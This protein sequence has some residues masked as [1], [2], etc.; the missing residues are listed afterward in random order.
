MP[1]A[2]VVPLVL[3]ASLLAACAHHPPP[4]AAPAPQQQAAAPAA[5][6]PAAAPAPE[7]A[8]AKVDD[9]AVR[10]VLTQMTFF[11]LDQSALTDQ[12]QATL[13]AK[14][15]ILA[16]NPSVAIRVAG[17][18]DERGSDE[19]NLALGQRRAQAAKRY[20]TEHGI[21]ETRIA[22]ISY[23]KERPISSGANEAAW[24]QNRNDQFEITAGGD[25]IK[26]P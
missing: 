6:A 22:I 1:A 23:G 3:G 11:S 26:A 5:P 17:N 14:V 9:S 8:P 25:A 2:R 7:P 13:A 20:L 16:A 18:C 21:A 24:A 4:A 10:S 15:P 12:G 19:Y